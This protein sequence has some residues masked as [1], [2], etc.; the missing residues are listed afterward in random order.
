MNPN[1]IETDQETSP[2]Y[3]NPVDTTHGSVQYSGA[4]P[5]PLAYRL[6]APERFD[7]DRNKFK[8]FILQLRLIF[9]VNPETFKSEPM[10]IAAL[11][12]LLTGVAATWFN[13]FIEFPEK[14]PGALDS[15][16][17]FVDR[18]TKFFG[19][20]DRT[21]EATLEINNLTQGY[22]S[23][24]E[25]AALFLRCS[26]DL[27]WNDKALINHFQRGLANHVKDMLV[28]L[29][30][31]D[32]DLTSLINHAIQFDNRHR[33]NAIVQGK[34]K[35][36]RRLDNFVERPRN[37]NYQNKPWY[38]PNR[39]SPYNNVPRQHDFNNVRFNQVHQ[40]KSPFVQP[41]IN[42][43]PNEGAPMELDSF[44]FKNNTRSNERDYRYSK[45][46]CL[47]CGKAGH[48]R[49]SCPQRRHNA[50]LEIF[51]QPLFASSDATTDSKLSLN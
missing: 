20:I 36:S 18:M 19:P 6:A 37:N 25:Y 38:N 9:M 49:A 7:G 32:R 29:P 50:G 43:L 5:K 47:T 17:L 22:K 39:N 46:L 12:N 23:V 2:F 21:F 10:K 4:T 31:P 35:P 1:P 8:T 26:E 14:H 48:L 3:S 28:M 45:G 33:E 40:Q 16:D 24:T 44:E 15:F 27:E 51:H 34:A 13:P 30:E 41:P 42:R 11:G